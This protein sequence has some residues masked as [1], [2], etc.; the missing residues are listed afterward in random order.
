MGI[1]V[2]QPSNQPADRVNSPLNRATLPLLFFS[3][4]AAAWFNYWRSVP[5]FAADL[6]PIALDVRPVVNNAEKPALLLFTS[7]NDRPSSAFKHDVFEDRDVQ[8]YVNANFVPVVIDVSK[9]KTPAI[10]DDATLPRMILLDSDGHETLRGSAMGKA[11][12]LQWLES[13]HQNHAALVSR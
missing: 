8:A 5:D 10:S 6:E 2:A 13:A 9:V 7:E 4:C 12:F 11:T 1:L 3:M